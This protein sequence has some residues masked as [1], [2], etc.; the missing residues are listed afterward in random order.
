[1][2]SI[3]ASRRL[4]IWMN[5]PWQ[6]AVVRKL[7]FGPVTPDFPASWAREHADATLTVTALVAEPP[8]FALR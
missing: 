3:L 5:R 8:A 4:S 1:M 7:L 2:K 6:K